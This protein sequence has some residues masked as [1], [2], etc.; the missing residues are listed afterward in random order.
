MSTDFSIDSTKM[1][2]NV[3][4]FQQTHTRQAN[5]SAR[6]LRRRTIPDNSSPVQPKQTCNDPAA[7]LLS[8]NCAARYLGISVWTL[9]RMVLAGEIAAVR[10]KHLKFDRRDLDLWIEANKEQFK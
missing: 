8:T 6:T 7:R 10:G 3:F 4:A 2:A 5:L 9:R 1:I